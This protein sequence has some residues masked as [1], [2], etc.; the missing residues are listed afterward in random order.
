M[1]PDAF[2]SHVRHNDIQLLC[3]CGEMR[4]PLAAAAV[5]RFVDEC[6]RNNLPRGFVIDLSTAL[7]MDSI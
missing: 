4:C 2:V 5:H 7:S 3:C 6:L 1:M